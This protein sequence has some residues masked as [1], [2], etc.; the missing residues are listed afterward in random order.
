MFRFVGGRSRDK[1]SHLPAECGSFFAAAETVAPC[2]VR[3]ML[4]LLLCQAPSRRL[5]FFYPA[6]TATV[7]VVMCCWT[8]KRAGCGT[9]KEEE[10]W[11]KSEQK[12]K[13][14]ENQ[15]RDNIREQQVG[16]GHYLRVCIFRS[17]Y[18]P[19]QARLCRRIVSRKKTCGETA[20]GLV[21]SYRCLY[22]CCCWCHRFCL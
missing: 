7:A 17:I 16:R 18:F 11:E 4:L 10:G 9:K 2:P 22:W 1:S 21:G 14:S 13:R 8:E 5:V 3:R 15:K 19:R 20:R 6:G 12:T